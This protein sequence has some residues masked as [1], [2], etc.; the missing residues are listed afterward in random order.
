MKLIKL[1]S[2]NYI[3]DYNIEVTFND[4]L[5]SIVDLKNELWGEIFEPLNDLN[6][7]KKFRLN[8]FTIEW[9]NGADFSP[10][11]LYELAQEKTLK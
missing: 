2:A 11:F 3:S 7:F 9:E 10:E 6:K 4:G 1:I 8:P 5:K